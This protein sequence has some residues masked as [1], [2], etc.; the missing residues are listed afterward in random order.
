MAHHKSAI[1]RIRTNEKARLRN[2]NYR[3]KMK[4]EIKKFFAIEN[5]EDAEK[6]YQKIV[7]I[8]DRLSAKKIIHKN[9]ASNEKSKLTQHLKNLKE[10]SK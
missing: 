9:K 10:K 1:K 2:K 4:Y 7:S 5:P 3:S 6:Q 8:L